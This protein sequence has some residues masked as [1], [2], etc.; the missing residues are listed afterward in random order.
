MHHGSTLNDSS[1]YVIV[2][3]SRGYKKLAHLIGVQYWNSKLTYS[4]RTLKVP[5]SFREFMA[6][7]HIIRET[8]DSDNGLAVWITR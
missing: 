2:H 8:P 4:A 5:I 1:R 6:Q 7:V 3:L